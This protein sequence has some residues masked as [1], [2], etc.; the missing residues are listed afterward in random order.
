MDLYNSDIIDCSVVYFIV[1]G[2]TPETFYMNMKNGEI[3]SNCQFECE[4][5]TVKP[6]DNV[7][8]VV[9]NNVCF[10]VVIK[11]CNK[12]MKTNIHYDNDLNTFI[13]CEY[14]PRKIIKAIQH[15]D[16][17]KILSRLNKDKSFNIKHT[18]SIYEESSDNNSCDD[19]CDDSCDDSCDDISIFELLSRQFDSQKNTNTINKPNTITYSDDNHIERIDNLHDEQIDIYKPTD[20]ESLIKSLRSTSIIAKYNVMRINSNILVIRRIAKKIVSSINLC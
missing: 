16:S 7:L 6:V 9:Y 5:L 18:T 4:E 3:I 13:C 2:Q 19:N 8:S 11:S 15:N 1:L 20:I 10:E 17:Y 12:L 14:D